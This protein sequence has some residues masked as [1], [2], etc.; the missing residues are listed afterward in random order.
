MFVGLGVGGYSLGIFH[1]FT[2]AF[3]KALLFLG[4]GSVITAMHHEQDM[5]R[6][7]GLRK[8]IPVTF[9]MMI[10]GTL[11]LT[12]FPL[13]AGYYSKDAI[14]EAAY[15]ASAAHPAA[16]YGFLMTV[17]AAAF[18]S[19]Y[20]WRL[21]FMTFFGERAATVVAGEPHSA[22]AHASH[23]HGHGEHLPQ[24]SPAVMLVPLAVL[25]VGALVAGFIFKGAFIGEGFDAF[26]RGA[27]A[28]GGTNHILAEMEEVPLLVSLL[29][30]LM[31][32]G[33]ALLAIYMYLVAPE[34][35]RRLAESIPI[36]YRFLL[37]KWY[38]DEIYDFIFVRPAFW[39]GRL[40]WKGGDGRIIDG[41]GP[42]GVA[43]RVIDLTTQVVKLQTGYVYHY[44]FAMLIGV[45]ALIT[46]YLVGGV[47]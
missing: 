12:G 43:A 26:W 8:V 21:I 17:I 25:A 20:S 29:P 40:L 4:A 33:G 35:P 22:L 11:S 38:F 24:E 42:D 39:I 19:F 3:F 9:W 1:L 23:E 15:A 10:I 6:M 47:H 37:N 7:G 2:H 27:V 44:A 13:T 5:R 32:L 46:W 14:I 41:I 18:T 30:T 34:T 45:A 28:Q 16:L 36:L 31:M